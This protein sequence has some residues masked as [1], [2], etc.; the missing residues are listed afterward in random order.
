[1]DGLTLEAFLLPWWKPI[2]YLFSLVLMLLTVRIA[3]NFDVNT[4]MESR[5]KSKD[6]KA[7][8]KRSMNCSHAW[9]L[10]H[11]SPYS[12]CNY[13]LAWI[14]TSTLLAAIQLSD[15]KPIIFGESYVIIAT[16]SVGDIIVNDFIGKRG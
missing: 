14:A 16:P 13:C 11:T 12:Q 15:H 5:R 10:Y 2:V 8:Q 3:I 7:R 6:I 9:T 4:W 1:M